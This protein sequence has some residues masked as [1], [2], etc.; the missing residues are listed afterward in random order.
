MQP[1][2]FN[3]LEGNLKEGDSHLLVLHL[4]Q[5][6]LGSPFVPFFIIA[7]MQNIQSI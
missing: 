3:D 2:K 7:A 6:L 1:Q 5:N 4:K